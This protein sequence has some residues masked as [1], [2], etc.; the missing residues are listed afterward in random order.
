MNS[1]T[2]RPQIFKSAIRAR[3]GTPRR[4]LAFTLVE[5]LTV[6][7]IIALMTGLSVK[8]LGG[9][10][11]G[12]TGPR[13]GSAIAA[14]LM[15]TARQEAIMRQTTARLV[16]DTAYNPAS[17]A[18]YLHRFTVAYLWPSTASTSGSNWL[19]ANKWETLPANAYVYYN[20]N[21]ALTGSGTNPSNAT[22]LATPS[23]GM[24]LPPAFG[25]PSAGYYDYFQFN[26]AGQLSAPI[27]NTPSTGTAE[28]WIAPGFI[29]SQGALQVTGSNQIFA[30]AVFRLG[31][32][33]FFSVQNQ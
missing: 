6:V 16:I 1:P 19:P 25:V 30:F 22:C 13:G 4:L 20:P 29:T 23:N 3:C 33:D 9:L 10:G 24:Q 32:I 5:L 8:I 11:N 2:A 21:P 28:L 27:S 31:R 17:P 26:S 15:G 12:I 18:N 14:S 7:A